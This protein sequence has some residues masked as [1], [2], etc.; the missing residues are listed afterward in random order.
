MVAMMIVI[1]VL[2]DLLIKRYLVVSTKWSG[3]NSFKVVMLGS[4]P[5]TTTIM[6]KLLFSLLMLLCVA[7]QEFDF[8]YAHKVANGTIRK[9]EYTEAFTQEFGTYGVLNIDGSHDWGFTDFPID[10]LVPNTRMIDANQ[11]ESKNLPVPKDITLAEAK[12][13]YNWFATHKNPKS[14]AIHWSDFFI[15]YVN[16]WN[17]QNP[18][19]AK[20]NMDQIGYESVDH[21][22]EHIYNFNSTTK[23]IQHVYDAGT[24]NWT[25]R[26][27]WDNKQHNDL[28][29]AQYLT[30]VAS[31]GKFYE[32][33]YIGFDYE[34]IKT[35]K[36]GSVYRDGYFCDYIVKISP[37]VPFPIKRIFVED[38]GTI[39]DF[40][41]NDVVFDC[42]IHYN[43]YWHG[44]DFGIIILRAAGGTMPLTIDGNEVHDLFRVPVDHMVNTENK[45]EL[46]PVI[47]RLKN[48]TS[49]NPKDI[50][51]HVKNTVD[52]IEYDITSDTGEAPGKIC[53]DK[54]VDWPYERQNIKDKYPKFQ[55]WISDKSQKFW[56]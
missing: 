24:E 36:K 2:F 4:S 20:R 15:Q 21:K 29:N 52:Y 37:A 45:Q 13:V 16:S 23:A 54:Q 3:H 5:T 27:S 18:D 14:I 53:I 41:F 44:Y 30:F 56:E 9:Q 7:C 31:D 32:G 43:P 19:S 51:I 22:W 6:K 10:T 38:L 48:I 42:H 39:G 1:L 49:A 50:K 11:W 28:Y 33:W 40:D 34:A 8:D 12:Y 17:E 26:S 47:F 35:H 25:Y 46:P 55:Q